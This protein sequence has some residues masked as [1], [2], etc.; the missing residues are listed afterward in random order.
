MR[1]LADRADQHL[2]HHADQHAGDRQRDH[3]GPHRPAPAVLVPVLGVEDV[4]VGLQREEE[5]GDVGD[6]ED[7]RD[8]EREVLDGRAVVDDLGAGAGQALALDQLEDRRHQQRRGRQQQHRRLDAGA[9]PAEGLLLAAQP[10]GQHRGAEHQQDVADDRADDRGLDH[11]LEPLAEREEGDDQLRRVAEGDVEQAADAGARSRGQ[12]LGGAAHQRRGGDDPQ[13]RG[14]E[15]HRRPRHRRGRAP[16]RSGS[17]AP[18]GRASPA[19]C[20]GR[21]RQPRRLGSGLVHGCKRAEPKGPVV[22]GPSQAL[23]VRATERC[24][25][26]QAGVLALM[27]SEPAAAEAAA[28]PAAGAAE[29][30]QAADAFSSRS[31]RRSRTGP[32]SSIGL[33]PSCWNRSLSGFAPDGASIVWSSLTSVERQV[34]VEVDLFRAA[35]G[36]GR[37]LDRQLRRDLAGRCCRRRRRGRRAPSSPRSTT[38]RLGL[39]E[40][41]PGAAGRRRSSWELQAGSSAIL[42]SA[43][44]APGD[45]EVAADVRRARCRRRRCCLRC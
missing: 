7:D 42:I 6:D 40:F 38:R 1:G 35:A 17:A 2:R 34:E 27:H 33:T 3:R 12:L 15:D 31:S 10:A 25:L 36:A 32:S 11:L 29:A 23:G 21:R 8:G 13:R 14:G 28:E 44:I 9:G 5:A 20:A 19:A 39:V 37:R 41:G 22:R 26:L 18:A 45:V 30:C 24:A 16:P 43:S 4:A